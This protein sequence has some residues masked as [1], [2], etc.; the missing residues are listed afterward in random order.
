M[1]DEPVPSLAELVAEIER[2]RASGREWAMSQLGPLAD[3][4]EV[5]RI[6][7]TAIHALRPVGI[8]RGVFSGYREGVFEV[9][10]EARDRILSQGDL[11]SCGPEIAG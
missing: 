9:C 2:G 8:S 3:L 10:Q 5:A 4:Q 6:E 1:N 11:S 7:S